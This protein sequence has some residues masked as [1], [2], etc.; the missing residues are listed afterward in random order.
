MRNARCDFVSLSGTQWFP[1]LLGYAAAFIEHQGYNVKFID[2][3]AYHLTFQDVDNIC[4]VYRPDFLV[5]YPGD[6]SRDSDIEY[7]DRLI[8]RLGIPAVFVGPYFAIEPRYFMEKSARVQ[9]GILGEFEHPLL[10]L[11]RGDK[12]ETIKNLV[13]KGPSGVAE[14]PAR[15]YL[16]GQELDRFPFVSDFFSR[17]LDFKRYRTPSEPH[18]FMDI[19]TGRGCIWGI[20]GFCL[21]VHTYVK[22]RVY[23]ARSI[24]NV[25]QEIEFIEKQLPSVRSVM[26]QD[27]TFPRDRAAEFC[28]AKLSRGLKIAWSCYTRADLD[29]KTLKLMKKAGCLN[30]HVGFESANNEVLKRVCK[31][32]TKECM[33]EFA[34]NAHRAG[35][36]IHGD[37]LI[38]LPGETHQSINE[39]IDWAYQIRPYTAQFQIFIPFKGTPLYKG[40]A[41]TPALTKNEL[42]DLSRKA[43]RRFYLS[44]F[45]FVR[46]LKN[47]YTLL[48]GKLPVIAKAFASMFW[49]KIDVR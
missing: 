49:R 15:P 47:P 34:Y 36:R 20:C 43:Y 5:M 2:A 45:Y 17:H 7:A 11:I 22:G 41:V 9:Y 35:V 26:I 32:L 3:P 38:G 37:F 6:K 46:I 42:E 28:E 31:G 12:P 25:I 1:L 4:A 23:N 44:W 16:T 24:G 13:R 18:P 19:L 33:T 8:E 40:Q 48:F 27:D 29:L 21:W 10:E 14:N 39:L 30:L